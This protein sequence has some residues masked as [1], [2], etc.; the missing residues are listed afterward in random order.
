MLYSNM[1]SRNGHRVNEYSHKITVSSN[2]TIPLSMKQ[3]N[4]NL[5]EIER[6]FLESH[7]HNADSI[8]I[9]R[10]SY[11]LGSTAYCNSQNVT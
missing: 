4:K 1:F 8:N 9:H 5:V 10:Y 6:S 2:V 7:W 3:T 11:A